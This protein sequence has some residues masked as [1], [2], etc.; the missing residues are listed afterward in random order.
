MPNLLSGTVDLK[1]A[2]EN[3]VLEAVGHELGVYVVVTHGALVRPGI[4]I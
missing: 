1:F 3:W 4:N 2:A